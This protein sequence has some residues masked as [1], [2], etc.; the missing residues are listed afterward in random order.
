LAADA[1][2]DIFQAVNGSKPLRAQ[3]ISRDQEYQRPVSGKSIPTN[4]AE[5][6][7]RI[8]LFPARLEKRKVWI[9]T[10]LIL[11]CRRGSDLRWT[12]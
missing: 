1:V 4:V 12:A 10:A 8:W 5:D 7:K 6:Q 3:S 9:P 11:A 2:P